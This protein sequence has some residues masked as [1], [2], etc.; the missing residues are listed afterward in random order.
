MLNG[1]LTRKIVTT[2][3]NNKKTLY[4][5]KQCIIIVLMNT[6][7]TYILLLVDIQNSTR[8]DPAEQNKVYNRLLPV[9]DELNR[10]LDPSPVLG[11]DLNYGDEISGLFE[12]PE[13]VYHA[14]VRLRDAL[15]PETTIR[16]VVAQGKI[17]YPSGDITQ[18]GGKIFKSANQA[19]QQ[20]KKKNRFCSWL[21]D[22]GVMNDILV[23]LSEMSNALLENMT[24]HQREVYQLLKQGH[25]QKEIAAR[26][27]KHQQ[28][29]SDA[30]RR[31]NAALVIEAENRIDNILQTQAQPIQ[32]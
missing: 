23:S 27:S 4:F 16:Y 30:V 11:L 8:M 28:S 12:S 1:E 17:G 29:V 15:Y 5:K 3:K 18:V 24:S 31:S 25:P 7:Q 13:S 22:M 10:E 32:I 21:T 6:I 19:M 26:L 9:I 14:V 2:A 20:L